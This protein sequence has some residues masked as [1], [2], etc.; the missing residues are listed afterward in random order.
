MQNLLL[1]KQFSQSFNSI[2]N[3]LVANVCS[4]TKN[5]KLLE[6]FFGFLFFPIY[7]SLM[8]THTHTQLL[9]F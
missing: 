7:F 2:I 6:V 9:L 4:Y 5:R 8:C 3:I 1:N